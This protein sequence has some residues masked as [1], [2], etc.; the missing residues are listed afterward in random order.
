MFLVVAS[1][2][3]MCRLSPI[4][5][6]LE[7]ETKKNNDNEYLSTAEES[8]LDLLV[9]NA[10]VLPNDRHVTDDGFEQMFAVN[11]LGE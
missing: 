4:K 6:L 1:S 7:L 3:Y 8:H 11:H 9:C 2:A 5:F 10:G